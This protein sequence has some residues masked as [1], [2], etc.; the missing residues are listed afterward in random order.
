MDVFKV[1][2]VL[3]V[4]MILVSAY[5]VIIPVISAPSLDFLYG[6]VISLTGLI[7]YFPFIWFKNRVNCF[8]GVT[9]TCQRLFRVALPQK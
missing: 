8:D 6:V 9:M 7:L 4:I 1:P 3:P 5:L 2:M